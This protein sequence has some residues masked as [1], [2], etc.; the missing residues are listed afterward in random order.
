MSERA[1]ESAN[2]SVE[3]LKVAVEDRPSPARNER[4]GDVR[5]KSRPADRGRK[6]RSSRYI[7]V[8]IRRAVLE[9]DGEQCTFVDERGHRCPERRRLE[10]DHVEGFA[11]TG[12]HAVDTLRVLCSM[13]NQRAAENMYGRTFMEAKRK[14]QL[15]PVRVPPS[16]SSPEPI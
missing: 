2:R 5:A 12:K 9:R 7:P 15:V 13:H 6:R 16:T 11:R 3:L 1:A 8:D 4:N 10:L 14:G